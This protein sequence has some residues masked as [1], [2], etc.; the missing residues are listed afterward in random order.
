MGTS[1]CAESPNGGTN[2]GYGAVTETMDQDQGAARASGLLNQLLVENSDSTGTGLLVATP[3]VGTV[4]TRDS[5]AQLRTTQDSDS[6]GQ[7]KY[8]RT[9]VQR[10]RI[11]WK[12]SRDTE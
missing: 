7:L 12:V 3:V 11:Q 8:G 1:C 5:S 6:T 9:A 2:S 4:A 10:V